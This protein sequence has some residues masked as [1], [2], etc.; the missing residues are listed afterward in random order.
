VIADGNERDAVCPVCGLTVRQHVA[1]GII[2]SWW[3]S[4]AVHAAPCGAP[5]LGGGVRPSAEG[6]DHTHRS[7][8]CGAAGCNGGA[9]A[10]P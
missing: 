3:W 7:T 10:A 4:S 2:G 1:R 5:C 6:I 8:E 9:L